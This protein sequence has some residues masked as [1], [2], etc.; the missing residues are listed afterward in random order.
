MCYWLSSGKYI[1]TIIRGREYPWKNLLIVI[2]TL[3]RQNVRDFSP[4]MKPL[5]RFA[6]FMPPWIQLGKLC[7]REQLSSWRSWILQL[8]T[9]TKKNCLIMRNRARWDL[10]RRPKFQ[11]W[12]LHTWISIGNWIL[13]LICFLQFFDLST[14]FAVLLRFYF[15]P[16]LHGKNAQNRPENQQNWNLATIGLKSDIFMK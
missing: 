13:N 3:L 7:A 11:N 12:D 9:T 14:P 16:F 5:T 8:P 2:I 4:S 15:L 10:P 1:W 6:H